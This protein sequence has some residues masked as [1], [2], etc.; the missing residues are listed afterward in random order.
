M[1][2]I[3][4]LFHWDLYLMLGKEQSPDEAGAEKVR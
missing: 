3:L 1:G 4:S 2:N